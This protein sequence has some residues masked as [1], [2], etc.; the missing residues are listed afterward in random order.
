MESYYVI[1]YEEQGRG[2]LHAHIILWLDPSDIERVTNEI[3]A[4]IPAEFNEATGEFIP[5]S[6][7]ESFAL[8]HLVHRKNQH[9]CRKDGCLK[10]RDTCKYGYPFKPHPDIEASCNVTSDRWDYFCPREVDRNTVPYHAIVFL[11]WGAHC[12]ALRITATCWSYYILKYTI[13]CEP[14]GKLS[15]DV[16]AAKRINGLS[17]AQLKAIVAMT[18][19]KPVSATTAAVTLFEIDTIMKSSS[20]TKIASVPP[21]LRMRFVSNSK[22]IYIPPV[23][24]YCARPACLSQL[25]F[26][27]YFKHYRVENSVLK[28]KPLIGR[29]QLGNYV[30]ASD[31][32]VR[33]TDY[34]PAHHTEG[35]FYNV[36]L[37]LVP[38]SHESELLSDAVTNPSRSYFYKCQVRDIIRSVDDI[39]EHVT[40]YAARHLWRK[41]QRQQLV[42]LI[43]QNRPLDQLPV[44]GSPNSIPADI[45]SVHPADI[46]NDSLSGN[47]RFDR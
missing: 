24:K 12:N 37:A 32:L 14:Y 20:I 42:D 17:D 27:E 36:L 1:R 3:C 35:Y 15:L 43:L 16:E 26:V 23:D 11:L 5:P 9:S 39:E 40:S 8:F 19:S 31:H 10:D 4:V 7:P 29:D 2:S 44:P 21:G 22:H 25:T 13:K 34:H 28:T 33:F 30:Y 18:M 38:F 41:E 45:E 6:D 46:E 47:A